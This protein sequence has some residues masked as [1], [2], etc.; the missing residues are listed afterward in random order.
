MISVLLMTPYIFIPF[1]S[2]VLTYIQ[3]S[4]NPW[5]YS[6]PTSHH[7]DLPKFKSVKLRIVRFIPHR[8]PL[9]ARRANTGHSPNTSA[10]IHFIAAS[11]TSVDIGEVG[12]GRESDSLLAVR[13][14]KGCS[15]MF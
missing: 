3:Q 10:N 8:A 6:L 2:D 5:K 4:P 12:V 15:D 1:M 9:P 7:R 14:S 11:W 13:T